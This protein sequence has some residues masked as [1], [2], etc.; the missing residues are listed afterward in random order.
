MTRR[1]ELGIV[2]T[3][4]ARPDAAVV[5]G[6]AAHGV[7]TVH[8]A[9]GRVGLAG[10]SITPI[11][12]GVRVA[13]SAVT[14]LSWPGDNL[15]IHAAIEQCRAGDIL[16]VAT[17]SPS[18]D[19]AFGD[20]FATALAARGVRGLVTATGVRDTQDLREM[21]FPAWSNGV[22]SQ[23]TVKA[24]AGSVNVP[25]LIDGM[26][27]HPGDVVI[28]DDDGVVCVP[29]ERAEAALAAA[30]A[31]VAKEEADRAA[32]GSGGELSL[33]RKGLR[34][35]LSDLGVTYTTQAEY[36]DGR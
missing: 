34:A 35:L 9:M 30:E 10:P 24:T 18:T 6:L 36:L 22:H 12:R 4:I 16:V 27:V 21:G 31:R 13:G 2:V 11:Q 25:V 5:D 19:G 7:A 3:D 23:G 33:D 26:L 29:R 8:E 20:L 17:T 15:M 14:V 1:P 28:A 32:Y